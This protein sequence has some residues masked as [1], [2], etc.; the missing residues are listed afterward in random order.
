MAFGAT[1]PVEHRAQAIFDGLHFDEVFKTCFKSLQVSFGQTPQRIGQ[2]LRIGRAERL[3]VDSPLRKQ[4]DENACYR[5]QH[6]RPMVQFLSLPPEPGIG[7]L[8]LRVNERSLV[9]RG[10]SAA[11]QNKPRPRRRKVGGHQNERTA[12]ERK[13]M[14]LPSRRGRE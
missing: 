12:V 1:L 3:R 4:Q 10:M 9:V 2:V 14:C 7:S 8:G 5:R 13:I 11:G 6:D